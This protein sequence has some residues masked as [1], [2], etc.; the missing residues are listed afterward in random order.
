[1]LAQ[2]PQARRS[3]LMARPAAGV[4]EWNIVLQGERETVFF[5]I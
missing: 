5:D 4:L 1:V 3:T 2:V